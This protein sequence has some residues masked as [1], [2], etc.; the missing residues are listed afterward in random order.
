M[1]ENLQQASNEIGAG[2][3]PRVREDYIIY[4]FLPIKATLHRLRQPAL[5]EQ[6]CALMGMPLIIHLNSVIVAIFVTK[7]LSQPL[8]S[9]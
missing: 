5:H 3:S 9:G 6:G 1:V 8:L 7:N 2:D 4:S